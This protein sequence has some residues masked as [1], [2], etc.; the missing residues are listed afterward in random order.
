M[1]PEI[2]ENQK[3]NTLIALVFLLLFSSCALFKPIKN[4]GDPQFKDYYFSD[5]DGNRIEGSVSP[6]LGYIYLNIIT[7]N[8]IGEK[9]NLNLDEDETEIDYIHKGKYLNK[10]LSFKVRKDVEKIKLHIYDGQNK[11]HRRL[12]EKAMV[13]LRETQN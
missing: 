12:K 6:S 3:F 13:Q 4:Q 11:R 7:E 5:K 2:I 10:G 1:L 9:V 8:A